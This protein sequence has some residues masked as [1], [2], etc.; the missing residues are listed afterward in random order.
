MNRV[1]L[2]VGL[3]EDQLPSELQP[4]I[5]YIGVITC[6]FVDRIT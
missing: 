3:M 5:K 1:Y 6:Y 2:V 4:E